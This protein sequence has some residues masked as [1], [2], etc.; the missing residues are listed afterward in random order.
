M[1][2]AFLGRATHIKTQADLFFIDLLRQVGDVRIWRREDFGS[3]ECVR[4]VNEFQPTLPSS[5]SPSSLYHHIMRLRSKRKVWVPMW[6]GFDLLSWKKSLV[7]RLAGLEAISFCNPVHQHLVRQKIRSFQLRY[8][9]EPSIHA[10]LS[11]KPPYTFFLWQRHPGIGLELIKNTFPPECVRKV[12][13]KADFPT[14]ISAPFPIEKLEGW[15]PK[16]QLLE[17]MAEADFYLAPRPQEGIGFSFL[18]AMA[19]GKIVLAHDDATMNEYIEEGKTG[20]LFNK[21]H[22][23]KHTIASPATLQPTLELSTKKLYTQWLQDKERL[24]EIFK[25]GSCAS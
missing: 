19:M 18:E 14:E 7:Y 21:E 8:F 1:K 3:R 22:H 24:V 12:I 5:F 11:A 4:Q 9:P 10:P 16:E 6:D 2:I 25:G 17:R 15:I 20:Y 23:F 13:Y